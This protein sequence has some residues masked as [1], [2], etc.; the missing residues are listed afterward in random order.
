VRTKKNE[1]QPGAAAS[2][3][4]EAS[5][6]E[7]PGDAECDRL[8]KLAGERVLRWIASRRNLAN[9]D[10][11]LLVSLA[12]REN[13]LRVTFGTKSLAE[14]CVAYLHDIAV[15]AKMVAIGKCFIVTAA[16]VPLDGSNGCRTKLH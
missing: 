2:K 4:V 12:A 11:K 14:S 7:Q 6:E 5:A 8:D 16:E 9:P 13:Y 3:P 15:Q 1:A 10:A